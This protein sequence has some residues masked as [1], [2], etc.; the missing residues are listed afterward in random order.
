V[1]T[2]FPSVDIA[3]RMQALVEIESDAPQMFYGGIW[4]S[5]NEIRSSA[6][7]IREGLASVPQ[8]SPIG[9]LCR[10]H[11]LVL[12]CVIGLLSAGRCTLTFPVL[13][14]DQVLAGEIEELAPAVLIGTAE[15]LDRPAVRGTWTTAKLAVETVDGGHNEGDVVKIV[16]NWASAARTRVNFLPEEGSEPIAFV[17]QTS[18]TTGR[19]KRVP[20]SYKSLSASVASMEAKVAKP[21]ETYVPRL[22]KSVAI[23]NIPL[24]HTS[25]MLAFCLNVSQGRRLALLDKFE[26]WEWARLVR[27]WNVGSAGLP[28]AALA[29]IMEADIPPS[30]LESLKMIRSGTAPL[31]PELASSFE[32]KYKI[33]V[34]QA[35]GA[36]EFQGVAS[37]T[38]QDYQ[39]WSELKRG[40]VGRAHAGVDLRVTNPDT[41]E[42]LQPG[43]A[44][45]LE[46]S[47][48]QSSVK[49]P[50]GWVPTSDLA[51]IDEDGFLWI[52]GRTDDIINR[53][54]LK[55]DANAVA[56]ALRENP[57]VLDAAVIGIP[58]DRLG[59]IPAAAVVLPSQAAGQ[60][61]DALAQ[62]L[63]GY[64]RQ[65]VAPYMVPARFVFVD[66]IP[67]NAMLKTDRP[68]LRTL[69]RQTDA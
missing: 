66:R 58:D 60:D 21:G 63:R 53:G 35:Y 1:E 24:S 23:L 20:V 15:D 31:R 9:V 47:S 29:M 4:Y 44:G 12:G 30:W 34:V 3:S 55:V 45:R 2:P 36:T 59:E 13:L 52:L 11:P 54:G 37:W 25:A 57:A 69:F 10:N 16:K 40:S 5:W 26:P 68:T 27:D 19:P 39:E 28:P 67:L 7:R 33:P 41:G 65:K 43:Q 46:I 38:L 62:E 56:A 61:K 17:L 14:N 48:A 22:R 32:E 51:R 6:I 64:L 50:T 49:T 18:G 8:S 42:V